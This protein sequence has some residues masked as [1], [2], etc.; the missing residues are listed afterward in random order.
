LKDAVL[1]YETYAFQQKELLD[2]I[3]TAQPLAALDALCAG[4]D[5]DLRSGMGIL[6]SAAQIGRNPFD[7]IP[8]A[9]L[10]AWCERK[11]DS[12]YPAVAGG[13]TAFR[14]EGDRPCW[15]G[16][17]RTL[18]DKAPNRVVVLK[19][20]IARFTPMSWTGSRAA[21]VES[22][23][24]LLDD[25]ATYQDAALTEFIAAEKARLVT[26]IQE[27]R[28]MQFLLDRERDERFES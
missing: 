28:D 27:E 20:F 10:L 25:L 18:L 17:A 5:T 21:I 11:P 14:F 12:R 2:I 8:E 4:D 26:V 1:K 23:V 19:E 24:R 13:V 6:E 3:M 9:D 16:T 22:N 15:T 7:S